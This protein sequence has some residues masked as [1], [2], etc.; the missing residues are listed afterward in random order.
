[1]GAVCAGTGAGRFFAGGWILKRWGPAGLAR[2]EKR[3]ALWTV[4]GIVV[5]VGA[6]AAV[7]LL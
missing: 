5:L 3:L 1:L 7:K 6:I 2:V 4:I